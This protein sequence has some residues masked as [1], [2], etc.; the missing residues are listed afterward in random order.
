M[1]LKDSPPPVRFSF[2]LHHVMDSQL[3]VE[4]LELCWLE[5]FLPLTDAELGSE[6]REIDRQTD[7]EGQIKKERDGNAEIDRNI[8]IAFMFIMYL[9]L[10]TYEPKH[11]DHSQMKQ[12]TMIIS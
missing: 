2:H 3:I 6:P 12:K 11:Y 5:S 4:K 7:R 8:H 1:S 9:S 10:Y